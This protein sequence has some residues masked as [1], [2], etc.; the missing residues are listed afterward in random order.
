VFKH[1]KAPITSGAN[2][3][4]FSRSLFDDYDS[5]AARMSFITGEK[6]FPGFSNATYRALGKDVYLKREVV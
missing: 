2:H 1:P 6:Y 4:P 3:Y 5:Q